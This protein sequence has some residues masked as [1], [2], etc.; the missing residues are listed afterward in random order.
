[1]TEATLK[2]KIAANREIIVA[3]I[4]F[5]VL[6]GIFFL[7]L[8]SSFFQ[9][10]LVD[11]FNATIAWLGG[12]IARLMGVEATSSSNSIRGP[13]GGITIVNEC[14][15]LYV[16]A[17]LAAAIL[18]TPGS[19]MARTLGVAGASLAIYA[20]NLARAVV[21]FLLINYKP[22]L[23]EFFHVYVFE[24]LV[25]VAVLAIFVAWTGWAFEKGRASRA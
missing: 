9:T 4:K 24:A 6:I 11:G 12:G 14:N 19:L 21:L 1:M 15:G 7:A 23:F 2:S 3:G 13:N 5:V 25:V 22:S 16:T 17:L 10:E 18:A 20:I 8:T